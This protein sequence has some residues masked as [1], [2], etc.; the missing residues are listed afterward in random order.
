MRELLNSKLIV[1]D[2]SDS[3]YRRIPNP[4][5]GLVLLNYT[6][7]DGEA[8]RS[9]AMVPASAWTVVF[10]CKYGSKEAIIKA[11]LIADNLIENILETTINAKAMCFQSIHYFNESKNQWQKRKDDGY[12]E[13]YIRDQFLSAY[14]LTL[15]YL[16]C[17]ES[18]YRQWALK[19]MESIN[20]EQQAL[21]TLCGTS[22]PSYM[23]GA[24]PEFYLRS[25]VGATVY[26][27][28]SR[29]PLHLGDVAYD[30]VHAA[31][32]A[33]GNQQQTSEGETYYIGDI[34][35]RYHSFIH[36]NCILSQ[37]G[38][39]AA[40]G[41]PYMYMAPVEGTSEY[42]GK[43]LS[44]VYNQ[45]GDVNWT[46]DTV[47]W[48]VLGIAK[49]EGIVAKTMVSRAKALMINGFFSD[50]YTYSG[51]RDT[52]FPHLATQASVFYLEALRFTGGDA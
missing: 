13:V 43:N 30:M 26:P 35:D 33:F 3:F 44:P 39:M 11:K 23:S 12:C 7:G 31:I 9:A 4:P 6:E 22:L 10:L 50:V 45:W 46:S 25:D 20:K 49:N 36:T 48:S 24:F 15:V 34:N 19:L 16:R 21:S 40:T 5:L 47:L 29:V 28:N 17:G 32:T 38:I 1:T 42:T 41:L 18:S 2:P 52:E 14:A 51:V 27:V 37:R 8:V